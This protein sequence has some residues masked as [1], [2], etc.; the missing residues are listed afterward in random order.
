MDKHR[1][2]AQSVCKAAVF[3]YLAL[4]SADLATHPDQLASSRVK[5]GE[6]GQFTAAGQATTCT[7]EDTG[8]Q[9]IAE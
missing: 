2:Q 5:R 9:T 3:L 7:S 6:P 4:Y 8:V 1:A